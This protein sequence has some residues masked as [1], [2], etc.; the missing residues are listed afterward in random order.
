MNI[1]EIKTA[2]DNGL[3]VCHNNENYLVVKGSTNQYLIKCVSNGACWGLTN[4]DGDKLNGQDNEFF[5]VS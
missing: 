3:V 2:V 1:N 5:I 4:L